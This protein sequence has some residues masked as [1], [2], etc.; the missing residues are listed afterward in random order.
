MQLKLSAAAFVLLAGTSLA[1]IF[2][3]GRA[4]ADL[5]GRHPA[6]LHA[7]SDLR[8]AR[9]LIEHRP[10]QFAA[11]AHEGAAVQQIDFALHDIREA[12]LWDGKNETD[13]PPVDEN[14]EWGGRIHRAVDL[15][16]DARHDCAQPED[17]PAARGLQG[18]AIGHIDAAIHHT[19]AAIHD[20][21]RGR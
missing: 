8:A 5:P 14:G 4:H 21:E 13:H 16:R 18:R 12:G 2:P 9:W 19:E 3:A 11:G 15:L 17:D 1:G 20:I 10:A 6:Y 7:L